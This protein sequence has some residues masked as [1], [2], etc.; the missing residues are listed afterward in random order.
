MPPHV[1][2]L[3]RFC[4]QCYQVSQKKR[5]SSW[6][7]EVLRAFSMEGCRDCL[8]REHCSQSKKESKRKTDFIVARKGSDVLL[9]LSYCS[10]SH[11]RKELHGITWC[12]AVRHSK[13]LKGLCA[14]LRMQRS[15]YNDLHNTMNILCC[16]AYN[17]FW[18]S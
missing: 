6:F 17:V 13:K 7:W 2:W 3:V 18:M 11:T 10:P 9:H 12:S 14:E 8:G 15:H 5:S 16:F 4:M 1:R